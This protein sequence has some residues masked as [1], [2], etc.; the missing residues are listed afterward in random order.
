MG[1]TRAGGQEEVLR[2]T[3]ELLCTRR[4]QVCVYVIK[5]HYIII[6]SQHSPVTVFF[7]ITL[8]LLNF[9]GLF[10]TNLPSES[11]NT[12]SLEKKYQLLNEREEERCLYVFNSARCDNQDCV[13]I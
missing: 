5:Y 2:V 6:Y 12:V 8:D 3:A 1:S 7:Y 10:E 9:A 4:G 13:D 11:V